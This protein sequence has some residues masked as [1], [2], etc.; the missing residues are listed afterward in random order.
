MNLIPILAIALLLAFA[1]GRIAVRL[2]APKV[3]GYVL[4]GFLLG[5][6]A[7]NLLSEPIQEE[8]RFVGDLAL[9]LILFNI[10]GRFDRRMMERIDRRIILFGAALSA[11]VLLITAGFTALA[12]AALNGWPWREALA[13]GIFL[14]V[15]ALAAAPPTTLMV[16]GECDA[17]GPVTRNILVFLVMGTFTA[18]AGAQILRASYETLG[19]WPS[20]GRSAAGMF[21]RVAW[22]LG[23][24]LGVGAALGLLLSY[25]EQFEHHEGEV[26]LGVVC[27]LLL[28]LAAAEMFGLEPMMMCVTLGCV[29]VNSS[30]YGQEIHE[31]VHKAVLS[32]Y[33]LF[34]LL[35]GA[36]I[37]LAGRLGPA[38]WPAAAYV[39]ARSA[40]FLVGGGWAGRRLFRNKEFGARTGMGLLSHAGAAVGIAGPLMRIEAPSARA[41]ANAVFTS[42]ILFEILGPLLLKRGL[43]AAGEVKIG[44]LIA[45]RLGGMTQGL[46]DL[47][48]QL[49][50]NL[51]LTRGARASR[52]APT[53]S[54][55]IRHKVMALPEAATLDQ[56]IKF[57][58][59][60]PYPIYPVVD[61]EGRL[62]GLL[63]LAAVR[64]EMCEPF[65][66]RL[67]V[68]GDLASPCDPVRATDSVSEAYERVARAKR[69]AL[70]VI[71]PA[72]G[73][74]LGVVLF[75]DLTAMAAP[76]KK[77]PPA[78]TQDNRRV[79]APTGSG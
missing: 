35:A 9:G 77:R 62:S 44:S 2:G 24:S 53:I 32:V 34:F 74:Y 68:A 38:L 50:L 4:T 23:G 47:L 15:T 7:T 73:K 39:L 12:G 78:G 41:A 58:S 49:A 55:L 25:W 29:L 42:I 76:Q 69:Q 67:V 14:G 10:G 26:L 54:R 75:R 18:I 57:V 45:G 33:A 1:A 51:G 19:W 79:D 3:T 28:G 65:L 40:G 59:E 43:L 64:D 36:H 66:F 6:S 22:S 48:W 60:H 17:E 72:D 56:I 52:E 27:A 30:N 71:D 63:N 13:T 46:R 31:V 20:E 8:L 11:V 5:P 61:E 21:L 16:I 37:K 70:P